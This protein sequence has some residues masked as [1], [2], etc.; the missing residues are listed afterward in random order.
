MRLRS[1]LSCLALV[2]ELNMASE[3]KKSPGYGEDEPRSVLRLIGA[4]IVAVIVVG[5]IYF[6]PR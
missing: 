4:I 1:R 2:R 6:W 5:S 3:Y